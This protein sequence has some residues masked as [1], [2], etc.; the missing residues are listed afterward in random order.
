MN[1]IPIKTAKTIAIIRTGHIGDCIVSTPF[2]NNLRSYAPQATIIAILPE[3]SA[4]VLEHTG[5]VDGVITYPQKYSIAKLL[6]LIR[7][8]HANIAISLSPS[9]EAYKLTYATKAPHRIGYYHSSVPLRALLCKY[10]YLNH[11]MS[12]NIDKP[13][14]LQQKIPHEIEILG[15][16]AH[17]IGI[18]YNDTSL[19]LILPNKEKAFADSL[20]KEWLHPIVILQL[21]SRWLSQGWTNNDLLNLIET[22]SY[23]N[24]KG[25][26]IIC[27]G[28]AETEIA[29][30]IH[31]KLNNFNNC[32]LIG[33]LT[34]HQW[35]SLFN[36]ADL[37]VSPE[38]G[39]IHVASGLHKPV[40]AVYEKRASFKHMQEWAPWQT[41]HTSIVKDTSDITIGQ[42][43]Q[44]MEKYLA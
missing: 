22:V 13:T 44:A 9:T 20:S 25:S 16:L 6:P 41:Q 1:N 2:F 35:I 40:I 37:I 34:F 3:Y 23:T 18:P 11:T 17:Y 4:P 7:Y 33:D 10:F 43:K 26:L 19:Q 12:V 27:Y 32:R 29:R 5:L 31:T 28:S 21:N 39:S 24:N 30:T 36:T 15:M 38:T 42:I 14:H 8:I